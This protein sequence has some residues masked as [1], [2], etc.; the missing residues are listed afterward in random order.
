VRSLGAVAAEERGV[1][2]SSSDSYFRKEQDNYSID[3]KEGKDRTTRLVSEENQ[4]RQ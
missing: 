2:L 1:F 4:Q 3:L